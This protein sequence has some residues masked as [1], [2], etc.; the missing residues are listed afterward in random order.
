ML[1]LLH[2]PEVSVALAFLIAVSIMVWKG[3]PLVTGAL[4]ARAVKIKADLDEAA[5]LRAEAEATLKEF[6]RRQ[7]EALAEASEIV[8]RA[9]TVG[10]RMVE[11]AG[12]DLDAAIKRREELARDRIAQAEA[13]ATAEVRAVAVEI[14][15]AATRQLLQD[16]LDAERGARLIDAAISDLP[17]RLH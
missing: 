10:D 7:K 8:A 11:Q 15:I 6:Q 3:G 1:E 4:D 5:R 2:D 9:R 12:R 17:R 13:K 14:A 16:N